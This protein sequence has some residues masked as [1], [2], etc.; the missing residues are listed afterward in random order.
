MAAASDAAQ[1]A[2]WIAQLGAEQYQQRQEATEQ[3]WAVGD[4]ALDALTEAS[5][6]RDPEVALRALDLLRRIDLGITPKT[7]PEILKLAEQYRTAGLVQKSSIF[8]RLRSL[9]AWRQIMRLY[10]NETDPAARNELARMVDGIALYA[11]RERLMHGE[12]DFA[13]EFLQMSGQSDAALMSI[14]AF[15]RAQ[16]TLAKELEKAANPATPEEFRWLAALQRAADDAQ[17]AIAS[18]TAAGDTALA[19]MLAML[20]GDPLPWLEWKANP[21][22][23]A[24][25]GVVQYARTAAMRWRGEDLAVE[26]DT[27]RRLSRS[28]NETTRWRGQ[29]FL[30]LLGDPE[31]AWNSLRMHDPSEAFIH[32]DAGERVADALR[33]LEIDPADPDFGKA[34]IP[35]MD[36]VLIGPGEKPELEDDRD[37][38]NQEFLILCAFLEKRGAAEVLD[39]LVKPRLLAF[40]KAH[41]P[42][43]TDLMS[44]LFAS[45][46]LGTGASELATRVAIEW[47]GNDDGRWR[48]MVIAAFG[49]VE[50]YLNWWDLSAKLDPSASPA[51]RM[52][53]L[54]ALFGYNRDA[55]NLYQKWTGLAWKQLE[56][57]PVA[58][59]SPVFNAMAF[60]VSN[61]NDIELADRFAA[62]N[63]GGNEEDTAGFDPLLADSAAERWYRVADTFL[64]QIASMAGRGEARAEFHAYAA[65]SLRRAGRH[66]EVAAH[67]AWAESLALGDMR[68][69]IA[70][71]QAYAF[72]RD[73]ARAA[74]WFRRALMESS[75]DD[76]RFSTALDSYLK[77]LLEMRDFARIAA[78]SEV[79]A[80]LQ[81]AEVADSGSSSSPTVFIILRQQ[82]DFARA[83]ALPPE[84]GDEARRMLR[85]AHAMMP[86][87]GALAD[88]F[89]PALAAS[90]FTD[91]HNE[92]FEISWAGFAESLE[93]FPNADNTMNT[94]VW[95]ASR[96]L[97]RLEE[98]KKLQQRALAV[99]FMPGDSMIIRQFERFQHGEMPGR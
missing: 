53:G 76:V 91:L 70:I 56:Q 57:A 42:R 90:R 24:P 36:R 63:P 93:I 77:E 52:R 13:L 58:V 2:E 65:A 28:H 49:E 39:T 51:D 79:L 34:L 41:P 50:E 87:G 47:A 81:A 45:P 86:S 1:H 69:N 6:S 97:H 74:M 61:I 62:I 22:R 14:A 9:K 11:A 16:G 32:L 10:A 55:D 99:R 17:G 20:E 83:M 40:G 80:Q 46:G 88:Y 78:C 37:A 73:Y 18:A 94:A 4:D 66:D 26:M 71:G 72:G 3:L 95:F 33:V 75:P 96:S 8:N 5:R 23:R 15:H 59:E 92:L 31:P 19:A 38:A 43:F 35:L 29:A 54:L 44:E 98:A 68:T 60:L 89:F 67:E 48:E 21:D 85:A 7:D 12:P 64:Q 27:I 82:A 30:F 84:Q 25:G